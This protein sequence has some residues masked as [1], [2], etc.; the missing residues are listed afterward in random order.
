MGA[1]VSLIGAGITVAMLWLLVPRFGYQG[2]AWAHLACYGTMVALSY[3]LGRKYYPVPYEVWRV[4][5]YIAF[6]LGLYAAAGR[7]I[8]D[9]GWNAL[10]V[11]TLLLALYLGVVALVD[12]RRLL[13]QTP[14]PPQTGV[15]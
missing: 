7:L 3:G 15:A 11:G 13:R 14:P 1:W 8:A 6:G 4:I 12:G 10:L 9:L 2:A 5:A